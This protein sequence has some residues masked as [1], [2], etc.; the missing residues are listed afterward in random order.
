MAETALSSVWG[1]AV[2]AREKQALN[3]FN[4]AKRRRSV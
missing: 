2:P 1:T 3:L 4:E